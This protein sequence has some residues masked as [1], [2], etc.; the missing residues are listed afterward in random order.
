MLGDDK[1]ELLP[2]DGGLSMVSGAVTIG[3][4]SQ[5]N[6]PSSLIGRDSSGRKLVKASEDCGK[7]RLFQDVILVCWHA[8]Y[9]A[10][11]D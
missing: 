3:C 11:G 9:S 6:S 10:I 7:Y 1:S 2:V 8:L 5:G 4:P